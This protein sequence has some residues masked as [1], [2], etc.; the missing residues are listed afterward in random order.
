M[1]EIEKL[2][3][4][5]KSHRAINHPYLV[6]LK[7]GT[8]N[9]PYLAI[10]DFSIQYSGYTSWFP[11]FLTAAISKVSNHSHRAHLLDNLSEESG[12]IDTDELE[13][14]KK[15]DIEEEW[16]QGISHPELFQRFKKSLDIS[17]NTKIDEATEI[18]RE[19]F[20]NVLYNGS[21][22]EVIGAIGIGTE[23]V[24]KYIYEY[25]TC[26]IQS[27]TNLE[28]YDYVFFELHSEIDDEHGKIM[29]QIA[30]DIVKSNPSNLKDIRKG[31]LKAL[32]LRVMFW[33]M[34]LERA[35]KQ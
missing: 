35:N 19:M 3:L 20:L 28:K 32:G 31:M 12:N 27:H 2:V 13:L 33:D 23:S 14:L 29:I 21:E 25:I 16:V 18:W 24:V 8:L 22:A 7:E 26:G 11:R 15:M 34:M 9:N 4:E 10:K 17:D 6:A 30:E 5:A 1:T